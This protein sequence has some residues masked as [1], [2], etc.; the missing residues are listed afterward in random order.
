PYQGW[1]QAMFALAFVLFS[2]FAGWLSDRTSKRTIVVL[3]KVLEIVVM[4]AA[5]LVFFLLRNGSD[6][7]LIGLISVLF[8]MGS[9]SAFF[10]PAKYG[11]LAE[12]VRERDLP[13][14]NGLIQM[15]TMVAIIGGTAVCGLMKDT[16]GGADRL[17]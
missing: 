11:I 7:F 10:G 9:Q 3:S 5:G 17:W 12:M 4:A 14:A 6:A 16:L 1:A 13:I 15:T 2:G 8:L